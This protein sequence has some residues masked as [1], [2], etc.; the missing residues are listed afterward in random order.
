M[1]CS[2]VDWLMLSG[3]NCL[4]T[5]IDLTNLKKLKRLEMQLLPSNDFEGRIEDEQ[6]E[7]EFIFELKLTPEQEDKLETFYLYLEEFEG[8]DLEYLVKKFGQRINVERIKIYVADI[9]IN[10][11]N[12]SLA[13]QFLVNDLY[14]SCDGISFYPKFQKLAL[15]DTEVKLPQDRKNVYQ[16][17]TYDLVTFCKNRRYDVPVEVSFARNL[18]PKTLTVESISQADS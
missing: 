18:R 3:E 4:E 7:E 6:S 2:E 1:I 16:A 12:E 14:K 9:M 11:K 5:Q 8:E 13:K 10:D 15:D 17:T